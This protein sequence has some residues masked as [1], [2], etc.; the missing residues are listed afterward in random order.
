MYIA[1]SNIKGV[2]AVA[3]N[4]ATKLNDTLTINLHFENGSIAN[5]CYFAN[6]SKMVSKEHLEVY[7]SGMVA[8][9]NDY[10][11]MSIFGKSEKKFTS[12]QDKGHTAEVKAFCDAI[13]NGKPTPI[14]FNE[15]YT[16]MLATF[17]V[18][19]SIAQNGKQIEV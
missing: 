11:E 4:D 7:S 10:K 1:G 6:G 12:S 14:S 15:I 3:L 9:I 5:I 17:K 13:K 16:S 8:V 2:S 19:E 18:L